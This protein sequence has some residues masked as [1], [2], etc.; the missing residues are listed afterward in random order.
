MRYE[1]LNFNFRLLK[2]GN[3]CL[4]SVLEPGDCRIF[5][6][7]SVAG[8]EEAVRNNVAL[9]DAGVDQFFANFLK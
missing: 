4:N 6:R 5:R 9:H 1:I 7:G 2:E 8:E 3:Y